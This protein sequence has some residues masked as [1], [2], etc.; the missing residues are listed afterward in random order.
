MKNKVVIL[1]N[2]HGSNTPGKCS[3]DKSFF[4]WQ[5]NRM[6]VKRLKPMLEQLGYIVYILVPEDNDLGLTSVALASAICLYASVL[7]AARVAR[8]C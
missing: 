5:W 2:G 4:E 6:F 7:A 3:P 8:D 1:D